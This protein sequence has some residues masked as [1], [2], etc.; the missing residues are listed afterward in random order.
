VR[1]P[2][3]D[4]VREMPCFTAEKQVEANTGGGVLCDGHGV[5]DPTQ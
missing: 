4:P 1:S 5:R 3:I 2:N